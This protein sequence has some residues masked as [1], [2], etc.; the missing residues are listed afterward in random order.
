MVTAFPG[1]AQTW[2]MITAIIAIA[3]MFTGN[4]LALA[5]KNMKRLLAYSSIAQAGYILIGVAANSHLGTSG[6]IYYLMA[7]L[8]TNLAAFGVVTVVGKSLGS[9]E[10]SKYSGLSRRSPGLA[11]ALLVALLSLGGIPPF[12]GFFG[13]LVVFGSAIQSGLVWLALL[14]LV[15]SMIALYYYLVVLKVVY[16]NNEEEEAAPIAMGL[17]WKIALITCIAGVIILGT[18]FAPWYSAASAAASSLF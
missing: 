16:R 8:L 5:Q 10:I 18:I 12:A 9:D 15:N 11:L 14:G 3:S 4:L 13:K 17:S 6:A 7:Y 2:T 1:S